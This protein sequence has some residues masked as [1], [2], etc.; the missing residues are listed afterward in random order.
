MLTLLTTTGCRAEAFSICQKLMMRQSYDGEVRWLI[1]D[2]GEIDQPITF[3][4]HKWQLEIIKPKH[5][6][7]EGANTQRRNLV[8]GLKHI[9]N[10]AKLIII[11]DDDYYS[12]Y[13]LET[14][15]EWLSKANLVGESFA[16][17]YNLQ[18]KKYRQLT[19]L[20]H[21]SLCSTAMKGD[22]IEFFRAICT[23][24]DTLIDLNLW[25]KYNGAKQLYKNNMVVGIKGL[26]GRSGIGIGHKAGFQGKIDA[27]GL[28]FSEW[29]QG[30][31]ALYEQY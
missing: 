21:S 1:I 14:A 12:P 19:N 30:D 18:S 16:R 8:E 31:T 2:D 29:L 10:D 27:D 20:F 9:K 15:D 13:Y 11:E 24:H 28:I 25:K 26:P 6:W 5:R 3:K 4:R 7:T 23:V 22:A 17:Y